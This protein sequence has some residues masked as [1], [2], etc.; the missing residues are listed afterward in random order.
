MCDEMSLFFIR[1]KSEIEL[2]TDE[3][4]IAKHFEAYFKNHGEMVGRFGK[5]VS[6]IR[7]RE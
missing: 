2:R 5:L 7:H 4:E 1:L 6:E 3:E